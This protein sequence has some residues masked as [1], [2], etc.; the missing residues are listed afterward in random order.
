SCTSQVN[1][2]HRHP[3]ST[4]SQIPIKKPITSSSSEIKSWI[5][6]IETKKFT[7]WKPEPNTLLPD[8]LSNLSDGILLH[9][10]VCLN[11]TKNAVQTSVLSKR[12]RHLWTSVQDL[13]FHRKSFPRD[14]SLHN[15]VRAVLTEQRRL[16]CRVDRFWY[17]AGLDTTMLTQ[18]TSYA[19][20]RGARELVI[21]SPAFRATAFLPDLSSGSS[22]LEILHLELLYIRRSSFGHSMLRLTSLHLENVRATSGFFRGCFDIFIIFPNLTNLSLVWCRLGGENLKITGPKIVSLKFHNVTDVGLL[23][24][25]LPNLKVFEYYF[26]RYNGEVNDF[27]SINLPS[28]RH[29]DLNVVRG[30]LHTYRQRSVKVLQGICNVESLVI[31]LKALEESGL[32]ENQTSPFRNLKSLK[33]RYTFPRRVVPATIMTYF[34][35]GTQYSQDLEFEFM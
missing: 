26:T 2:P 24:L 16:N 34:T 12:W 21:G 19:L 13:S 27:W 11:D 25:S 20:S 23:E 17:Y 32:L 30:G 10:L 9:I 28:L 1:T 35:S 15:F 18:L 7:S 29:A 31:N 14:S 5:Y 6:S 8:R 22:T 4:I 33:F 3:P